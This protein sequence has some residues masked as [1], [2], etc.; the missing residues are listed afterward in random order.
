MKEVAY[1]V[2]FVTVHY[3]TKFRCHGCNIGDITE[4]FTYCNNFVTNCGTSMKL[5]FLWGVDTLKGR[6]RKSD[7][8]IPLLQFLDWDAGL[9]A[10]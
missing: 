4:G 7:C 8:K 5:G 1:C 9:Q 2:D 6:G 3:F 10:T